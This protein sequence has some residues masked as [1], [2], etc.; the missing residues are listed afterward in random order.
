MRQNVAAAGLRRREARSP[1]RARHLT[2]VLLTGSGLILLPL[3]ALL[4]IGHHAGMPG[5]TADTVGAAGHLV[6][7]AG[8]ALTTAAVVLAAALRQR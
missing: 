4:D 7:L 8:M 6:T 1:F 5:L 3:G 2:V